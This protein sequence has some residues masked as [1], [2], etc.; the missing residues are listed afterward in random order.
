MDAPLDAS[1]HTSFETTAPARS[2]LSRTREK[3][4]NTT[5]RRTPAEIAG[6]GVARE[7]VSGRVFEAISRAEA[8]TADVHSAVFGDPAVL[9]IR[10]FDL[11][12]GAKQALHQISM[13][14]PRGKV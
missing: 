8:F 9:E 13:P 2:N 1:I 10:R 12:Y 3:R 6:A 7:P 5:P 4:M 14:V 11:W